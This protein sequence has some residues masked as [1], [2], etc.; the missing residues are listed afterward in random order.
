MTVLSKR[1]FGSLVSAMILFLPS[2]KAQEEEPAVL[3]ED[4]AEI[5]AGSYEGDTR[6]T[7]PSGVA[8]C[9]GQSKMGAHYYRF[10]A[11]TAGYL[12]AR[13]SR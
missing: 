6:G 5:S 10:T 12:D 3:C 13:T 9:V 7:E 11:E 4:A 8:G 1:T 2:V